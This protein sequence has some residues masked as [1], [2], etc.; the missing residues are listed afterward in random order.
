MADST[1]H[2][3]DERQSR[4]A[5]RCEASNQAGSDT[6]SLAGSPGL[7]VALWREPALMGRGNDQA[8]TD[9]MQRAQ[10]THGNRAVQR[11]S[12][13]NVQRDPDEEQ[14]RP[15]FSALPPSLQLPMGPLTGTLTPGGAELGYERGP[16]HAGAEYSWGGPLDLNVGYG[17]PLQ[18]WF[19]DAVPALSGGG[20]AIPGFLNNPL[21]A[22]PRGAVGS[23]AGMLGDIAGSGGP[24]APWGVGLQ[25]TIGPE[26]QRI[27]A[28][29]RFNL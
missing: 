1:M 24:A 12:Q 17:A 4:S 8:R 3:T 23:M 16:L 28:G 25:A 20:A 27:M 29:L 26:E 11:A 2:E 5:S 6:S 15:R 13:V 21:N 7:G 22:G 18:P 9:V 19:M 10:Q 14:W